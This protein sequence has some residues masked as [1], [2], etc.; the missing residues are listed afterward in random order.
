MNLQGMREPEFLPIDHIDFL[1]GVTSAGQVPAY[2]KA[3]GKVLLFESVAA[4]DPLAE[5]D[6]GEACAGTVNIEVVG[7]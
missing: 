6:N 1:D 7:N 4:N 3:T 2:Y 5:V